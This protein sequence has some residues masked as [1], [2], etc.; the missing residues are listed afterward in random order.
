MPCPLG[1]KIL[2]CQKGERQAGC[3]RTATASHLSSLYSVQMEAGS[4]AL[5]LQVGRWGWSWGASSEFESPETITNNV[6]WASTYM[7]M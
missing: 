1:S 3:L 4:G 2:R 5:R 7:R 6:G